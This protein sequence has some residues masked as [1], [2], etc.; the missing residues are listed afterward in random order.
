MGEWVIEFRRGDFFQSPE[1]AEGGPRETAQ[2]FPTREDVE[3][4]MRA[5]QWVL[6]AGGMAVPAEKPAT[7]GDAV[8]TYRVRLARGPDGPA[9]WQ[10]VTLARSPLVGH[11]WVPNGD[12][13]CGAADPRVAVVA[14]CREQRWPVA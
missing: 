5:N 14:Y 13:F 4:F 12:G 6:F 10:T 1:A 9:E 7:T 2:R 3:A 8:Q 11:P